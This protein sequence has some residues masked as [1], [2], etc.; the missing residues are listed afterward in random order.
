MEFPR[1]PFD[2]DAI[3][4]SPPPASPIAGPPTI[5]TG[6]VKPYDPDDTNVSVRNQNVKGKTVDVSIEW[7][8]GVGDEP[9]T[10]YRDTLITSSPTSHN[11]GEEWHTPQRARVRTLHDDAGLS[12]EANEKQTGIPKSTAKQVAKASSSRRNV[13][14]PEW[15]E[16]RG[17]KG[18]S[19]SHFESMLD[20]DTDEDET[21]VNANSYMTKDLQRCER[22][23]EANGIEGKLLGWAGLA[24]AADLHVSESTLKRAMGTMDYHMCIACKGGWA[25]PAHQAKRKVWAQMMLE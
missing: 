5:G 6:T 13:H 12:F 11:L 17:R 25:S 3:Q 24:E 8:K 23:L 1:A 7:L 10:T 9:E 21:P 22:I 19:Q 20:L 2:Y 14:D 4:P 16:T 15:E 18:F